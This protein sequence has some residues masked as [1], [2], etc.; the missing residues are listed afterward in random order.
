MFEYRPAAELQLASCVIADDGSGAKENIRQVE[1]PTLDSSWHVYRMEW[2]TNGLTFYQDGIEYLTCE[3]N[4]TPHWPFN[5]D[6]PQVMILNQAIGG[7]GGGDPDDTNFPVDLLVDY[8]R[9]WGI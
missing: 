3:A 8:V 4:S 2:T 6:N 5:S 7:K 1:M 9:V